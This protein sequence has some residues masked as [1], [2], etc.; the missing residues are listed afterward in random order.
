MNI[1]EIMIPTIHSISSDKSVSHAARLMSQYQMDSLVVIDHGELVGLVTSRDVLTAHPNRIVADAMCDQMH[2]LLADQ[3]I[4]EAHHY[5][6][7]ENVKL[8]IVL[9]EEQV[10]G[11]ITKETVEMKIAEYKDPLSGLYRAPY[12]QFI[13][14]S[15]L[16]KQIPFHLL[17]ID[18]NDFGRINK[19]YGHPFGDDVIRTYSAVLSSIAEDQ[20]DHLC[21][22]AG[23]EF[24]LIST[25]PIA[26]IEQ[27]IDLIS[28]PTN[29]LD[30]TVSAA[31][32]HVNGC[33]DPEF[34]KRSWRELIAQAS[35]ESS[36][37]KAQKT[38]SALPS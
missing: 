28:R 27:Y 22:Y 20:G 30:I 17:F 8:A 18:L 21:R 37:I 6:L 10:S 1:S 19:Q 23:D 33:E 29:V 3:N 13:G 2:Y 25:A 7:N 26:L 11:M 24:V 12:I 36:A 15:Y 4:W 5:F 14:E 34:F 35:L 38:V 16:R 32:G 9:D 31:V